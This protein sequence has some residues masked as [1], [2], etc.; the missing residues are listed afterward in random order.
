MY[1][2]GMDFAERDDIWEFDVIGSDHESVKSGIIA[3]GRIRVVLSKKE[4]PEF[5]DAHLT[6]AQMGCYSFPMVTSVLVR[7]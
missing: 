1:V 5:W 7:I 4:F 6:A 3:T 2:W